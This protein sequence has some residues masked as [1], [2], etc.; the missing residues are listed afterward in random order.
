MDSAEKAHCLVV[1][2]I[3]LSNSKNCE[4]GEQTNLLENAAMLEQDFEKLFSGNVITQLEFEIGKKFT[5]TSCLCDAPNHAEHCIHAKTFTDY[6]KLDLK[7][8]T[9]LLILP[10]RNAFKNL[11][12]YYDCKKKAPDTTSACIVVPKYYGRRYRFMNSIKL[13]KSYDCNVF[14]DAARVHAECRSDGMA[15]VD[16]WYDPAEEMKVSSA[17]DKVKALK[18]LLRGKIGKSDGKLFLDTGA[19]HNFVS[20][21]FVQRHNID[22]QEADALVHCAGSTDTYELS[23]IVHLRVGIQN[24]KADLDFYVIELPPGLDA[25]LGDTWLDRHEAQIIYRQHI[26]M[27]RGTRWYTLY[28]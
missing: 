10:S 8:H 4:R 2:A 17:H 7:G 27:K 5:S 6:H 28:I 26:R 9:N 3:D 19:T 23:G 24:L 15:S 12:H 25:C 22:V 14:C 21:D 13:L 1:N 20:K 18:T 11:K 16:V